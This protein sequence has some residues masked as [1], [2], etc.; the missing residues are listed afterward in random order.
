MTTTKNARAAL[1]TPRAPG[2][3]ADIHIA[4]DDP[5]DIDAV[6]AALDAASVEPAALALR[7]LS[8]G[9]AEI[10]TALVARLDETRALLT[11]HG[12]PAVVDALLRAL[13]AAGVALDHDDPTLLYP[14]AEDETEALALHA[15]SRAASPRAAAL[16]LD[17][18]RRWRASRDHDP[19]ISAQLDRLVTP[20]TV[21]CAGAPNIGKST[22]LNAL[23]GRTVSVVADEPG[24]TRDHVGALLVLDALCV[25]W[26][27]AP[28]LRHAESDVESRA[29]ELAKN[30][31]AD[32]DLVLLAGDATTPPPRP[33]ELGVDPDKTLTLALRADLGAAPADLSLSAAQNEGLAHLARAVRQRLV[34][35][36]VLDSPRPW[37]FD[38][39]LPL[40]DPR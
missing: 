38:P 34:P 7:T 6:L 8:H 22:L 23:A 17:Q 2:A 36:A 37:R 35:D 15:L 14:E 3:I 30:V 21:V 11:P 32:A 5:A 19:A 31:I 12:G 39:R 24:V 16:L 25:R 10:D 18:P 33:H 13:E 20:P 29:I 28:G 40:P 26:I 9:G 1:A 27:D 4:A